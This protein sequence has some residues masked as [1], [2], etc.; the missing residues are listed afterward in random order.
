MGK[1]RGM[2]II[3]GIVVTIIMILL[4]LYGCAVYVLKSEL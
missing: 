2:N 3:P 4:I 1:P